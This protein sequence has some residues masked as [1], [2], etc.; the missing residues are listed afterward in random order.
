ME[1]HGEARLLELHGLALGNYEGFARRWLIDVT[2]ST[3]SKQ[4]YREPSGQPTARRA[5]DQ[6][7][8]E[9]TIQR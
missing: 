8:C 3:C 9:E 6:G 5:A 2:T 1:L 4:A 7:L